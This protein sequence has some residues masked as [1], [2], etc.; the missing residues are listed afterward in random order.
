VSIDPNLNGLIPLIEI[1]RMV[2]TNDTSS[3]GTDHGLISN[4]NTR[5]MHYGDRESG[6]SCG[7]QAKS[8]ATLDAENPL[9]A[10]EKYAAKPCTRCFDHVGRLNTVY[11]DRH[12]ATVCYQDVE[13][14]IE[15]LPWSLPTGSE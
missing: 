6:A 10:V 13:E 2:E 7:S 3:H 9:H 11:T 4:P 5:T 8:W 15:R 14:V 12:S 1:I